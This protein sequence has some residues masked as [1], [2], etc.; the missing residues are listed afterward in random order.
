VDVLEAIGGAL[1]IALAVAI[2]LGA[3]LA[4]AWLGARALRRRHRESILDRD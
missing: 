4:A 2:P 3:L 1:M